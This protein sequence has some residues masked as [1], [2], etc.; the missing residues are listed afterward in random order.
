MVV[1][2]KKLLFLL[3]CMFFLVTCVYGKERAYFKEC[4]DGDTIKLVINGEDKTVRLLA[5]DTPETVKPNSPLEYYGK[6]ASEFTCNMVMNAKV[7]ELE[8]EDSNRTDKYNRV[9]AWVFLDGVLLQDELVKGG[10]AS[11]AY[12]YGKYKYNDLLL[13]HESISKIN[14]VGIFDDEKRDEFNNKNGNDNDASSSYIDEI[15]VK[16]VFILIGL[17]LVG[18]MLR[19][20]YKKYLKMVRN[21]FRLR[22]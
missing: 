13:E 3:V 2:M 10:Y 17:F 9:L 19:I 21:V 14:K 8:Y 4:V 11:V 15:S 1:D 6:E 5:V 12:L 22:M 7:I 20:I 16:D 18:N